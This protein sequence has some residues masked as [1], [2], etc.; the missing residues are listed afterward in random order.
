M[1]NGQSQ[2]A[3]PNM[4]RKETDEMEIEYGFSCGLFFLS[5]QTGHPSMI[6]QGD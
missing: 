4:G 3:P 2:G 5:Q 6:C 1:A